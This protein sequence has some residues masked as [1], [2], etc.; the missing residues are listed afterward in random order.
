MW[1][2]NHL[3]A[4]AR[5]HALLLAKYRCVECGVKGPLEVNH[6][7][8]LRGEGYGPS[9]RHHQDNL[10]VLCVPHHLEVTL[11]QKRTWEA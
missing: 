2:V 6:I 10:T 11:E 8:P 9:C 7:R 4:S 3:W 1:K 5:S